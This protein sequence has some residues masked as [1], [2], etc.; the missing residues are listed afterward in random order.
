MNIT[1]KLT[2]AHV[3]VAVI[4]NVLTRSGANDGTIYTPEAFIISRC[5]SDWM[6]WGKKILFTVPVAG[7]PYTVF[8]AVASCGIYMQTCRL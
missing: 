3:L 5:S 8:M 1:H 4:K 6:F 2:A 7:K